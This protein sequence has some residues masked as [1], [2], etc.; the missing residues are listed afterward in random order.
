MNMPKK[1]TLFGKR[2]SVR[3][4]CPSVWQV[5]TGTRRLYVTLGCYADGLP[6]SNKVPGKVFEATVYHRYRNASGV[7]VSRGLTEGEGA[8]PQEALDAMS[9][10][11]ETLWDHMA[12]ALGY[13]TEYIEGEG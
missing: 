6:V 2:R 1:V 5:N 8:T 11:F 12:A 13:E 4:I 9:R 7:W 10:E 3:S